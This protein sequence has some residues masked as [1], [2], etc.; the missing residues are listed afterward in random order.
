MN[1]LTTVATAYTPEI[2]A[3]ADAWLACGAEAVS[4]WQQD[5]LLATW[6]CAAQRLT[7]DLESTVASASKHPSATL[8]VTGLHGPGA[9]A[10]LDADAALLTGLT[11]LTDE[12]EGLADALGQTEDQLLALYE[13]TQAD[14]T[15]LNIERLLEAL[16][17]QAVRLSKADAAFIVVAP[18]KVIQCPRTWLPDAAVLMLFAQV[19]EAGTE[20]LLGPDHPLQT[21]IVNAGNLFLI[22]MLQEKNDIVAVLGLHLNR[23]ATQLSPDLKLVRSIAEQGGSQLEIA[24]LHHE[25]VAQARLQAEMALARQVQVSLLPRQ[26]LEVAGIDIYG[27]SR[28]ALQVGGDFYVFY[29]PPANATLRPFT[30]VIGDISGKGMSAAILMAMTRTVFRSAAS[31]SNTADPASMLTRANEDLYD[32]FTEVG[33]MATV[34]VGRYDPAQHTLTFANAGHSPVFYCPAGGSARLL[35]ADGPALGVLPMTLSENH[36]LPFGVGDVLVV[37]TDGFN[38]AR[39]SE[40]VAS[41][42]FGIERLQQQIAQLADQPAHAIAQALFV[43]VEHFAADHPQ[44]DDQTVVIIKGIA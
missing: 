41:E 7:A 13:L 27:E 3:L 9:Q 29:T 1:R 21:K 18:A 38:E 24:L 6:P 42:M 37:A 39:C 20:L 16:V 17:R 2:T 40:S 23:P 34:F 36:V 43:S 32:D 19:Q 4:L 35:A 11:R 22:P 12:V 8:R 15:R 33:M 26:A 10:R 14:S 31:Q 44:D 28:P 5:H 25:L 30:F